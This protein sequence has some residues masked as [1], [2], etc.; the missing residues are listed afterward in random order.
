MDR[1]QLSLLYFAYT[2][3]YLAGTGI[4]SLLPLYA[5]DF[6]A[7]PVQIGNFLA[8]MFATLA[9]GATISGYLSNRFGVRK[10]FIIAGFVVSTLMTILMGQAQDMLSLTI[11]GMI[12]WFSGGIITAMILIMVGIKA[13]RATSGRTF[14]II[15]TAAPLGQLLGGMSS[16]FIVDLWGF[17][18]MF[19]IYGCLYLIP[20]VLVFLLDDTRTERKQKAKRE[21]GVAIP[22][23][24]MMWIIIL[25]GVLPNAASFMVNFT[26]PIIMGNAGFA[27]TH[28]SAV[29]GVSGGVGI[30]LPFILGWL[31]DRMDKK[32]I[33]MI[34]YAIGASGIAML[35]LATALWQFYV[36]LILMMG[37]S[38]VFMV[39]SAL[40]K[41]ISEP[42]DL[43]QNLSYYAT[44]P[45]VG[46]VGGYLLAGF[47]T[48]QFG[49]IPAVW[50]ASALPIISVILVMTLRR[51]EPDPVTA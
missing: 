21:P 42:D 8:M 40:I 3:P 30:P 39:G 29:V 1:K 48:Q 28:I 49:L 38:S 44:T 17:E 50:I 15:G 36:A 22:V 25:A 12:G 2:M 7:S 4:I 46:G 51:P 37:S 27:N 10:P 5:V 18:T 16:G 43:D 20:L 31:S 45:W 11:V 26:R 33:L 32:L 34:G 47:A 35:A 6:G 14:G 24:V 19:T 13:D 23:N 9:I 41:D